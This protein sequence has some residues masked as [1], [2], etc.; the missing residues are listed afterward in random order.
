MSNNTDITCVSAKKSERKNTMI[1]V[2]VAIAVCLYQ[3]SAMAG[4]GGSEFDA[5]L[6][7]VTDWSEGTLGKTVA[8]GGLM[9]GLG[10]A[11]MGGGSRAALGGLFAAAGF[12]YGPDIIDGIVSAT[13]P[14]AGPV[15]DLASLPIY[16][17]Y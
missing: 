16:T 2:A 7:M 8:I 11:A 10:Y 12:S 3:S 6:Q 5:L 9:I 13:L 4:T 17:F 15:L 1:A 14:V